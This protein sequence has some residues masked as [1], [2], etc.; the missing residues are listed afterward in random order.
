MKLLDDTGIV[1]SANAASVTLHFDG[2]MIPAR[3]I[4]YPYQ[5][6]KRSGFVSGVES[7]GFVQRQFQFS[8]LNVTEDDLKPTDSKNMD[9]LALGEIHV[10][11]MRYFVTSVCIANANYGRGFSKDPKTLHEKQLKGRDLAHSVVLA[12]HIS[13]ITAAVL[14][15]Y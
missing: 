12:H 9:V 3:Y 13:S 14:M 8:K 1:P 5:S 6:L 2:K 10:S 15:L 11:V 7:G 4:M